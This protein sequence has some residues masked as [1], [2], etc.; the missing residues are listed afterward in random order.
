MPPHECR[1]GGDNFEGGALAGVRVSAML[2]FM[3]ILITG[4]TGKIG[5]ATVDRLRAAGHEATPA[6]RGGGGGGVSLELRDAEA[7]ERTARGYDAALLIM[8]LGPDEAE[9]GPRLVGA[10]T[11][12]GVRRIVAVGIQ[13]AEAMRAIPHFEAKLPMQAAVVAVGGTVLAC[14][15]FMQNDLNALPAILHGGVY[16]LPV[17]GTGVFAV[18][19]NDI[20]AAAAN[21]LTSDAWAAREIPV[22]GPERLTGD[23][24]AASWSAALGRPVRYGGDDPAP[25]LEG[26]R[27][28]M[29]VFDPWIENDFRLMIE[30]TQQMGCEATPADIATATEIVGRPL[31]RHID[32]AHRA[33]GQQENS[34]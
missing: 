2:D 20:A 30:V 27:R 3:R 8:P 25:F 13:N 29:P 17:G 7:V 4:G 26:M 9:L 10:L 16:P 14:N 21:A 33:L 34:R 12:A 5:R 11:G 31:T 6:S 15:W 24:F 32:F 1:G 19:T 18:D 28:A 22:C 23:G